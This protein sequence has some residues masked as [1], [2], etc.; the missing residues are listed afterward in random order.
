MATGIVSSLF[1]ELYFTFTSTSG[2]FPMP[3]YHY[4]H[5]TRKEIRSTTYMALFF[6]R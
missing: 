2:Q 1:R 5:N 6:Y 3:N 4:M